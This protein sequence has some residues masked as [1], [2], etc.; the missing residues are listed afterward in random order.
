MTQQK[1]ALGGISKQCQKCKDDKS[2]TRQTSLSGRS[3]QTH[4]QA[5]NTNKTKLIKTYQNQNKQKHN[6]LNTAMVNCQA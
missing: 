3:N 4:L 1:I 5:K 6:N 2:R